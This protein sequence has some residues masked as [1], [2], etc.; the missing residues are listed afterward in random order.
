MIVASVYIGVPNR[1]ANFG[2]DLT[3][4]EQVHTGAKQ[5][6]APA[7]YGMGAFVPGGSKCA[8]RCARVC[9]CVYPIPY[10]CACTWVGG[11]VY[12]FLFIYLFIYL[13]IM[14]RAR[15]CGRV[16]D[17][18]LARGCLYTYELLQLCVG[19]PVQTYMCVDT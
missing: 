19:A 15:M 14:S 1:R 12:V 11:C 18:G 7:V 4:F 6:V 2:V 9:L 3:L 8:C 5:F 16:C 10:V 13:F 17:N